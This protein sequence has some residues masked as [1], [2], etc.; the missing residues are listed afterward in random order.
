M[1]FKG[2]QNFRTFASL[3]FALFLSPFKGP[4]LVNLREGGLVVTWASQ[5]G[6]ARCR[7]HG[8]ETG[9]LGDGLCDFGLGRLKQVSS[10][11]VCHLGVLYCCL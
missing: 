11:R 8:V 10:D 5:W 9:L 4:T 2:K 6:M 1:S 3:L 7:E